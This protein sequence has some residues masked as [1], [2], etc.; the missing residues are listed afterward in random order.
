[1]TPAQEHSIRET[2]IA[3][4]Q[5]HIHFAEVVGKLVQAGVESYQVDYRSN[6][7]IYHNHQDEALILTMTPS[8]QTIAQ[9]FSAEKIVAAIRGAQLGTVMYPEFKRL[10]KETGCVGYTVWIVGRQ[11]T[12]FGRKGETHVERFPD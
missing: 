1:M 6:Q 5:G 3:S 7:S 10:S 4:N 2:F 9:E 12:Y 11:V 8:E